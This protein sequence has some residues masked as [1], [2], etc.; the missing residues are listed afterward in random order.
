MNE[1]ELVQLAQ[2]GDTKAFE[3]LFITYKEKVYNSILGKSRSEDVATEVTQQAFIKAW[4]KINQFK[5]NSSF[6]TWVYRI[7][8]NLFIDEYRKKIRKSE[9]TL[10]AATWQQAPEE[11]RISGQTGYTNLKS[12][13][14]MS[15]I[16]EAID[17]LSENH[18]KVL[19]LYEIENLNYRE[20]AKQLNCSIGTVMSRLFYARKKCRKRLSKILSLDTVK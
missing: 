2:G 12:K 4:T 8:H 7:A 10:D 16:N 18:K 17:T 11:D 15:Q 14:I 13:E 19:I 3:Q 6:Y 20:I 5:R 9:V 1:D